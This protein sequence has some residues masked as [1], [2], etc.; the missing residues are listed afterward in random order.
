MPLLADPW[1]GVPVRGHNAAGRAEC[2][3][4]PLAPGLTPHGLRHT[5]KTMMVELGTPAT[6]MDAQMGHANGSVQ[7]LYEHV[8]AGMT[9]RLVDGL[10]GVLE[11]AL[12]ARRRLSRHSPVRVLDGLLTEVP[13]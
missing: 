2:C 8:T 4:A 3:W 11:D 12:A 5:C 13:G 1:P 10:T 9:A 7:A 6:L